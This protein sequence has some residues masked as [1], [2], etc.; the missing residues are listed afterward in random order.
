[1]LARYPRRVLGNDEPVSVGWDRMQVVVATRDLP[2]HR[3]GGVEP[4]TLFADDEGAAR[5]GGDQSPRFDSLPV[6]SPTR[7]LRSGWGRSPA[8]CARGGVGPTHGHEHDG[9]SG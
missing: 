3:C 4:R 9:L 7:S 5:R 6:T 2:G 8:R 1:M